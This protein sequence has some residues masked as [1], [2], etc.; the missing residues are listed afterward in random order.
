MN[1]RASGASELRTFSHLLPCPSIFCWYFR[2]YVSEILYF[3]VS[4]YIYIDIQSMQFP[5]ITYGM[6]LYINDSM[7]TKHQ[8][9]ENLC[10]CERA[11]RASLEIF[12]IFTF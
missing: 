11:E 9:F 10:I 4:N 2:F 5:F 7:P 6:V 8:H 3:Q 12:C 1:M